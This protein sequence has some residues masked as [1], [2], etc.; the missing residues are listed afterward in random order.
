MTADGGHDIHNQLRLS[1]EP[2]IPQQREVLQLTD[3]ISLLEYHA[4]T[5][6]GRDYEAAYLDYWNATADED[7]LQP[8][9]SLGV[10]PLVE[11]DNC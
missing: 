10:C 6:E 5:V 11:R 4:L 7:G 3:P 9:P 1:E 2:L 8:V